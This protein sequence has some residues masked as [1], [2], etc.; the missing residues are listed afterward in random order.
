MKKKHK[1][2]KV[3]AIEKVLKE[4]GGAANWKVIYDNIGKFYHYTKSKEWEAGLRGVL[5]RELRNNRKFKKIG[6]SIYA[7]KNYKEQ[8][9][10]KEKIR[11]HSFMQGICLELGNARNYDTFTSDPSNL[12]RDNV[13]LKDIA[14]L[15]NLPN[16][17]YSNIVKNAKFI[18]ILWFNKS[19]FAFPKC[20]FEIVD[21][22]T[23][24][25]N[26]FNRCFELSAFAM[27]FII[28]APQKHYQK[29]QQNLELEIYKDKKNFFKFVNYDD[30]LKTYEHVVNGLKDNNW[31]V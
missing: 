19:K 5:Y 31:L 25:N 21:S 16:F 23:T 2:T 9:K 26:A 27:K 7:L 1:I 8:E 30:M 13:Y 29:F 6:L 10:P 11:M 17:T 20:A 24:L 12:Y 15:Q 28:V 22:V 4:N 18:D 14:S 3:E